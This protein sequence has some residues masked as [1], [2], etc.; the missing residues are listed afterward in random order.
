[1][2]S[3]PV[4]P[5]G[6]QITEEI[7]HGSRTIVKRA[8]RT[9]DQKPVVLKLLKNSYPSFGE[10]VQFRNQYTITKN[11]QIPGISTPLALEKYCN[12]YMLVMAD[13]GYQSLPS[14]FNYPLNLDQFF[15]IALQLTAILQG[16][17]QNRIIHKDIKPANILI[18]PCTGIVQ[19]IDF[20][21]SSLLAKEMQQGQNPNVLE[22]TL[23]YMSPE[24]TGRMNRC[25]DYRTDFYSLGVTFFQLLTGRLPFESSDPMEL[26]HCHLAKKPLSIQE[27]TGVYFP[28]MLSAIVMK[29]MA[30]NPEERYQSGLGL[31]SDLEQCLNQWQTKGKIEKF[32]LG[33]K[34]LCDRFLIPEKLYGREQEVKELL[35]AFERVATEEKNTE[36]ILVAGFSGIGKTAVVNEVHKPIV[37]QRGYFIKGKFDQF[38]RN[39]PFS[40][41]VQALRDLMGNLL[42]A[43]EVKLQQW[44]SKILNA[45]GENGQVIIDVIP[46]LEKIIGKQPNVPELSGSAAQ[47]RFNLLFGKF[48]QVFTTKEH[49]LVIF[50]DDLQWA[51]SASLNLLKLLMGEGKQGYLLLIGAYRDNEVFPAH[52]LMLTLDEIV[53]EEGKVKTITLSPLSEEN[54]NYLVADTLICEREIA[55]PLTEL[56]YQKTKG[57]PFFTT[58]FLLGLYR[59]NLIS[60]NFDLGYWECDLVEVRQQALIDDVVEFMAQQLQKLPEETQEM[61]KLAAC[62]GNQFDLQTLAIVSEQSKEDTADSLWRAL[63]QGFIMPQSEV[64]KFYLE[65]D[66]QGSE[67]ELN[68]VNQIVNYKFLHDRVQQAAYSLIPYENKQNIH[69]KIGE[70]M[71]EK[72]PFNQRR[73]KIFGIVNQLN[74]GIDLLENRNKRIELANLNLTAAQKAKNSTAYSSAVSYLNYGMKLLEYKDWTYEYELQFNLHKECSESEYLKGNMERSETLAYQT[75]EKAK[76]IVDQVDIYNILIVQYTVT[77]R[78]QDAINQGKK[79]LSILGIEWDQDILSKEL[80]TELKSVKDKLGSRNIESLINLPEVTLPEKK[81]AISVLHYLLPVAFSVNQELWS[82]FVVKMVNL[83]LEYGHTAECCFGYSFYGVFISSV[84]KD[85]EAGYKFGILSLKLSQKFKDIA[86]ESKACNILAAFLLHWKKHVRNCESINNQGYTVGLESGQ[87]QFVGYIIYNRILSIFHSGK[88]LRDLSQEFSVYLPV[89]EQIK[90]YYSLDITVGIELAISRLIE[91]TPQ[92][93]NNQFWDSDEQRYIE[94][95]HRRK[96][97]PAICIYQIIKAQNLYI[98]GQHK[99]ALEHL[100]SAQENINFINGHFIIAEHNYYYSLSLLGCYSN[101]SVQDR[102]DILIQ[103][104]EN[105]KQLK[106]WADNA[107]E[108]F[109]HNFELVEAEIA[110]NTQNRL[111]AIEQYDAAIAGAKEYEFPQKEALANELAAKFYLEWGKDKIA[112]AYMQEAYYCYARWGAKTKTEDLEKR[113]PNLLQAIINQEQFNSFSNHFANCDQTLTLTNTDNSTSNSSSLDLAT[114]VKASQVISSEIH[115]NQLLCT[116]MSVVTENSGADK[117]IF[118]SPQSG[119]L[120]IEAV[121]GVSSQGDKQNSLIACELFESTES[122][123]HNIVNYVFR[124]G[125]TLVIDDLNAETKFAGDEYFKTHQP[126]SIL[127]TP[128]FHQ[129]KI[130]SILY[131][132]NNFTKEAFTRNR[133]ELLNLLC[134]QAAISLE[135]ARLY[136][137]L[138]Q[139]VQERTRELSDTLAELKATQ[140]KLVESEKMAALGG[141]VAGVAHEINTPVGTSITVASNLAAKTQTFAKSITQGHLKRSILNNYLEIAQQSSD[142]LVQNLHRAGELVNSFKQVAVD[143][144]NLELRTFKVK[145]YIEGVLL[146]LAPQIKTSPHKITVS[147]DANLILNS[148]AGSLAQVVTNLVMNSLK[149]AYPQEQP[150]KLHWEILSE[151]KELKIIYED[152][153]CGIPPENLSKIF[154][155]FFTTKRNEGGTGL[156]LH[157]VYNLITHKLGGSIEVDSQVGEGTRFS[158]TL[159]SMIV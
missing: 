54:I 120:I 62:I 122:M 5:K 100:V 16:L 115:L 8:I 140:K 82:F 29:L 35:A 37:K 121:V 85:Y 113:Y 80:S 135:N 159:P 148:Y 98:L 33:K 126:Q 39:I 106:V 93:L 53:K 78:Y 68:N 105:Q 42:S 58:Q 112:A 6:Y 125:D 147:G 144:T 67:A 22:G 45:L 65:Q 41:L 3:T 104:Q 143:Q 7:Y 30:K 79:A 123:P 44:K 124:N 61:L 2:E 77:S 129:G 92:N 59:G 83:A 24:Q 72:I 38:N 1:M 56:V 60:F 91:P 12:G 11:L 25:L 117:G 75:L 64:Y 66:T 158:L 28:E 17:Y 133:L 132:E 94:T 151:E 21:I 89:L 102:E 149:H 84:F 90:H 145:E 142:L 47:H 146:S 9:S 155:P 4:K 74:M 23:A 27:L 40:A 50:L 103:V 107:Q 96:S 87:L 153:G 81:A 43:S 134:N 136:E 15:P 138:E 55:K 152:D 130:T 111:V 128:I 57:N 14:S 46:E 18:H 101:A 52:P 48:I 109:Q 20:S 19:I 51:D 73:E 150:G 119:K 34:D 49:P 99:A 69:L 31:R 95:C 70:L 110:R 139:K 13:E 137:N 127:C 118:I 157:I 131:L 10:L 114:V 97:F 36:L 76:S 156:G 154:E 141:L 86:Q 63:K 88:N 108:N 32:N 116:L 71:L 26:V